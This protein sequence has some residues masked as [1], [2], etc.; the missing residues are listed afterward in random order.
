[1]S[2]VT[3]SHVAFTALLTLLEI[4]LTVRPV[5]PRSVAAPRA[6]A[7]WTRQER[8]LVAALTYAAIHEDQIAGLVK[9]TPEAI[10]K[11]VARLAI[12]P[13]R[14]EPRIL[15]SLPHSSLTLTAEDVDLMGTWPHPAARDPFGWQFGQSLP[16][17]WASATDGATLRVILTRPE[18]STSTPQLLDWQSVAQ[19]TWTDLAATLVQHSDAGVLHH[20][21]DPHQ[22]HHQ[23]LR[24]NVKRVTGKAL[25][26]GS[27]IDWHN[28]KKAPIWDVILI[29]DPERWTV[30]AIHQLSDYATVILV[31]PD[32][33]H[34][35]TQ[36]ANDELLVP[37]PSQTLNTL[38]S[39]QEALLT[40]W[41][42]GRTLTRLHWIGW[43]NS[44]GNLARLDWPALSVLPPH[45]E[46]QCSRQDI[47]IRASVWLALTQGYR[48]ILPAAIREHYVEA[49][50]GIAAFQVPRQIAVNRLWQTQPATDLSPAEKILLRTMLDAFY[51]VGAEKSDS[52]RPQASELRL[53]VG[54]DTA[55]TYI[56][57]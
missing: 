10:S 8:Q 14:A 2:D 35:V 36:E 46:L 22:T 54:L 42:A 49:L 11:Q 12:E 47:M 34:A 53:S 3:R 33:E 29:A 27:V 44:H 7:T 16:T 21:P 28:V 13:Q 15:R 30:R 52:I 18:S 45:G 6:F 57:R 39:E 50:T 20:G 17:E 4:S 26:R 24:A 43:P 9:R 37:L 32:Y 38:Q 25:R 48:A 51:P 41:S 55:P 1:M 23:M 19:A 40:R 5:V 31:L 56:G